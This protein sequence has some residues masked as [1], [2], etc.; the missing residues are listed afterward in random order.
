MGVTV[1]AIDEHF[2]RLALEQ[3]QM[4]QAKDEVP[5]GALV[6]YQG[7]IIA[8]AHNQ[9]IGLNDPTAHAEILALRMAGEYLKNYRLVDCDLYVTLEPCGMCAGAMV[10]ARINHLIYGASDLKTGAI[11]SIDDTFLKPHQNHTVNVRSGVLANECGQILSEFFRM[12]RLQPK[13]P[14]R[15]KIEKP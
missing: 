5:V 13:R 9:T 15:N 7:E 2:M 10:H 1:A 4:A 3:A 8:K 11:Q 6:V 14:L 12:K